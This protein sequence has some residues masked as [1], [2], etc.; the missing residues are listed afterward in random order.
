MRELG[1]RTKA[2]IARIELCDRRSGD[3]VDQRQ[4]QIS[5]TRRK[6]LVV[7]DRYMTLAADSSASSRRSRHTC[8]IVSNTRPKPGRP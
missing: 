7:F 4:V 8:A 1:L 3:L 5:P 6:A 2:P